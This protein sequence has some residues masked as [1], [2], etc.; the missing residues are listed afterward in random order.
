MTVGWRTH[1]SVSHIPGKGRGRMLRLKLGLLLVSV[2]CLAMLL[3]GCG[4]GSS[5][6]A[7]G[8]PG[9]TLSAAPGSVSIAQ[10]GQGT[11]AITIT[12]QDGFS[13]SVTL[14]ASGLPSGVTASF[15][16]NPATGTSTLTLA[17]SATAS[18]G[19]VTVTTTG[20]ANVNGIEQTITLA[21]V[22]LITDYDLSHTHGAFLDACDYNSSTNTCA[23]DGA[24]K[25]VCS[26]SQ[27]CPT[28]CPQN[29]A[30]PTCPQYQYVDN[31]TGM[32]Q[33]YFTMAET[34]T[35]AD[36]MFQTNEGPSFPAHQ[37]L[38]AGTSAITATSTTSIA[39]NP[40]G[41]QRSGVEYAG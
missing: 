8:G 19:T 29:S 26:P 41:D 31:S 13:G 35:F 14:S 11:S 23:M 15:S 37:Y 36:R 40:G 21:P 20:M 7:Q 38:L 34:Y 27:N 3:I 17:A 5:G 1:A 25:I 39:D 30:V 6:N 24:N 28:S 9:F 16:P 18:T 32:I 10:G 4:G 33:P 12:P 22:S 2:V